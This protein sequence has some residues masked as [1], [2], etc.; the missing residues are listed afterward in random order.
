MGIAPRKKG[1]KQEERGGERERD[2]GGVRDGEG[3]RGSARPRRDEAGRRGAP[4]EEAQG[5]RKG[6]G[7]LGKAPAGAS[8][9]PGAS[10]PVAGE[11]GRAREA[12]L[13][14]EEKGGREKIYVGYARA[15]GSMEYNFPQTRKIKFIAD[16][17]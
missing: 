9:R 13:E 12:R 10:S 5:A 11:G 14:P 2:W 15:G 16:Q 4:A 8:P 3:R 17:I 1:A 6:P 7:G